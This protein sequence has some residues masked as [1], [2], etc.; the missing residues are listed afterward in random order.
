[1]NFKIFVVI[2]VIFSGLIWAC[3]KEV[4]N[5]AKEE[6]KIEVEQS[7][8]RNQI[9]REELLELDISALKT[10]YRNL[11]PDQK[12]S[13]WSDKFSILLT[14][15]NFN[16]QELDHISLLET[17]LS[18]SFFQPDADRQATFDFVTQWVED[19]QNNLSWSERE[20]LVITSTLFTPTEFTARLN[21]IDNGTATPAPAPTGSCDCQYSFLGCTVHTAGGKNDC[22][23]VG[24]E[25]TTDGC[26]P[27]YGYRCLGTC[28]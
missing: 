15:E 22:S 14:Q 12:L 20:A 25:R 26:G 5:I 9:T 23:D 28:K 19:A 17:Q 16:Q 27:F 4:E 1:M 18:L 8:F 21:A 6:V 7:S 3:N 2:L 13:I 10:E 24:C 11:S